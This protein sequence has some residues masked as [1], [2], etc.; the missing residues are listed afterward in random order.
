MQPV[1]NAPMRPLQFQQ[2]LQGRPLRGQTSNGVNCFSPFSAGA[3][4]AAYLP[5]SRRQS[6]QSIKAV[7]VRSQRCS[8][9]PPWRRVCRAS[10]KVS[11]KGG[12]RNSGSPAAKIPAR[13]QFTGFGLPPAPFCMTTKPACPAKAALTAPGAVRP[14]ATPAMP[15][16]LPLKPPPRPARPPKPIGLTP[17]QKRLHPTAGKHDARSPPRKGSVPG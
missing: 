5:Q 9:R 4:Q 7:A 12:S 8:L 14:R 10:G 1:R 13:P 2:P 6:R 11:P 16:H 17:P 3:L 15:C